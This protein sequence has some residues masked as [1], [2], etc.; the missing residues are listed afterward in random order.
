MS[1]WGKVIGGVAGFAL[2]GPLGAMMG[3]MAGNI[4]DKSRKRKTSSTH[5]EGIPNQQKQYQEISSQEK[6]H[7]F[8][9][10][11]ITL[12]AKLAKADGVVTQDEIEVFKEK[13]KIPPNEEEQIRKIF[14]EAQKTAY[15]F[16]SIAQQVGELF[17]DS[18]E[19]L[20][21]ILRNLFYVAEADGKISDSEL[22]FLK[23]VSSI[24]KFDENTF[25]RI[26][27]ARFNDKESDPYKVLGVKRTDNE[28]TIKKAWI[29]LTKEHHPDN[30]V[31]KGMPPEF[32]EQVTK[33]M[34]SINTAYDKIN[35]ERDVN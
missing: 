20:E 21:E 12:T 17:Q 25:Q 11:V 22:S 5:Q 2:G 23:T 14:N 29:R 34:T 4:Y 6:Q 15:G 19:V 1:V 35:K 30:L 18:H 24:F 13:F 32:I 31:A 10:S 16:E 3:V 27:Q 8:A 9:L 7:I 28:E 26:S 33:E